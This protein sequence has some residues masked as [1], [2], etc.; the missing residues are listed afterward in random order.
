MNTI[1]DSE[2]IALLGGALEPDQALDVRSLVNASPALQAR[3]AHLGAARA[4]AMAPPPPAWWVPPAGLSV[5]GLRARQPWAD[6]AGEAIRAGDRFVVDLEA[7]GDPASLRVVLMLDVEGWQVL[8]PAAPEESLRLADLP[9]GS[10]GRRL[11]LTAPSAPPVQR[12]AVVLM[13][14]EMAVDWSL[15]PEARWAPLREAVARGEVGCASFEVTL[16]G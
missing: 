2:L 4:A 6:V 10:S 16:S 3:L 8:L 13:P 1:T 15:E 12:W 11:E 9:E 5:G 7:E 14:E